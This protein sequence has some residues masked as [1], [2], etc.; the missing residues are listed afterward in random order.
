MNFMDNLE[1][2][3]KKAKTLTENY[4]VAYETS[5]DALLDFNFRITDLRTCSEEE[6]L[7]AFRKMFFNDK[8]IYFMWVILEKVSVREISLRPA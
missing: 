2:E 4:A 3:Q 5:G 7:K 8:N 6:I 1:K